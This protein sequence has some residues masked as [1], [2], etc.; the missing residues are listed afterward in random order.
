MIQLAE[1]GLRSA[2]DFGVFCLAESSWLDFRFIVTKQVRPTALESQQEFRCN[3]VS[4]LQTVFPFLF[5]ISQRRHGDVGVLR[6][7]APD[8]TVAML[9]GPFMNQRRK[10][11]VARQMDAMNRVA[12]H[13]FLVARNL[14]RLQD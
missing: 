3:F 10:L 1:S 7:F 8:F 11:D 12:R 9:P 4:R 5:P 6:V 13:E 14:V 2:N